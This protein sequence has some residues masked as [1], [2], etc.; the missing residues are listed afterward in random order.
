MIKTQYN[1]KVKRLRSDNRTEFTNHAFQGILHQEGILHET[2]CVGTPQQNARVERKHR[3]I[4]NVA[5][6]L[7]FQAN[8]PISFWG[9]CVLTAT[10]LINR[11][12]TMVNDGVTP[13]EKLFG[14]PPSY[15]HIKIFGC[16]CYVKNLSKQRDKFDSRAERCVF[17]GY[18][19]GQKGWTVYNL[20]TREIYVSRDVVFYEN[21]FPYASQEK[22]SNKDDPPPTFASNSCSVEEET[23][24]TQDRQQDQIDLLTQPSEDQQVV[25]ANSD[26][27][28]VAEKSYNERESDLTRSI[29]LGPR[30]RNPPKYLNNFHYYSAKETHTCTSPNSSTSSGM[31][32]PISNYVNYD[33]FSEK[34]QAYL[35]AIESIEEPQSYRQAT[36]TQEWRDA[37]SQELKALEENKTWELARLSKG[38]KAVGCR[39]VYKIKYKSSGEVEKYKARLVA[40]GYTQVEGDDFNETFAPV[41]KMTT[42]RCLLTVAVAKGWELHQMDVSNAFLHGELNEEVYMEVPPGYNAPND[43]MV[44]R[45]RKSLYG[46]RQA[47]RNWYSKLSQALVRYGFQECEADH[48]LFTYSCES[49][50]IA[51]LIYVDD[52]IVTGNDAK[53]CAKFKHYLSECFHMKDLGGL[54]Y[55]LGLE[56]VRGPSGLFMCQRK[57]TLDILNECGMLAC[58]PASLPL[59]PN[60]KLALDSSPLYED[61]SQYRRLVGRLIYLTITRPELAY[62][63]HILSQFM[64]KPHRGHWDAAMLVLRYLK[65]AP[66][67]G[68]IIPKDND[69][70]LVAYCD[71]DYA[72]CPL[73]S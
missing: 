72:S 64:Q 47:S 20:R 7:R 44:C 68:I 8:L 11:T 26:A 62:S 10:Y 30:I 3:H 12:P 19:K 39:W 73:T 40:K 54:K 25:E 9:E 58:K 43:G 1:G 29:E 31:V 17:V 49:V 55:F 65:S 22:G 41:A 15:E 42:V 18:P 2:S 71:S 14:K 50:F 61:P 5:R 60:H 52:L 13:Y 24:P 48:S 27:V 6:A 46:L 59:P 34:H 4:L 70:K 36:Q 63:V 57:Y 38:K 28:E 67:Q 16:L 35:A 45:L 56:L 69:L 51:V 37:M 23:A 21:V 33:E 66:G 32:Y 53:S